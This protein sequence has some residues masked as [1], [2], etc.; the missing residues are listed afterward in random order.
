MSAENP[1]KKNQNKGVRKV[2]LS[3]IQN[4]MNKRGRAK[5]HDEELEISLLELMESK[6]PNE[7][8]IWDDGF[9]DPNQNEKEKT[10]LS[11]K[12]RNRAN[13]VAKQ[14]AQQKSVAFEI[15][16]RYLED[17]QMVISKR[18]SD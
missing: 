8:I 4:R 1:D 15:T 16:V 11:S 10:K 3:D 18:N 9:V 14:I 6:D 12:F 17:G 13:S 7:A 2:N 5:F